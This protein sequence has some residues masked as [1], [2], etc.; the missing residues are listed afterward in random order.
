LALDRL[1][2]E[3]HQG[4]VVHADRLETIFIPVYDLRDHLGHFFGDHAQG[5]LLIVLP[6][7]AHASQPLNR[8]VGVPERDDCALE[9]QRAGGHER[10]RPHR[11]RE[12]SLPRVG[13]GHAAG[14]LSSDGG[15]QVVD[16]ELSVVGAR[17]VGAHHEG[18]QGGPGRVGADQDEGRRVDVAVH[19]ECGV[20]AFQMELPLGGGSADPHVHTGGRVVD[21]RD[22][23]QYQ[24]VGLHHPGAESQGRRV[25]NSRRAGGGIAYEGVVVLDRVGETGIVAE[26]GVVLPRGVKPARRRPKKGVSKA[27][28]VEPPG[29]ASEECVAAGGVGGAGVAP[30][31]GVIP[32]ERVGKA[33][34]VSEKGVVAARGVGETGGTPE[35]GVVRGRVGEAGEVS[36]ERVECASGIAVAGD[37]S[38]ER[39][40][41]TRGVAVAGVAA[42]KGVIVARGV[43]VAG[44][45]AE[46]GVVGARSVGETG[47]PTE[48]GVGVSRRIGLPADRPKKAFE[49]PVVLL[50]PAERP[51]KALSVPPVLE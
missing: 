25:G 31:E 27:P 22:A 45:I 34:V 28:S 21:S 46:E 5:G 16:D 20:V 36:E 14:A 42:E 2:Q 26:E 15:S 44:I 43:G 7:E 6:D 9:A 48:E 11:P 13:D 3:R 32:P 33:G 41:R 50:K 12:V 30:E 8:L 37:V 29:A 4:G 23:P 24:A 39:V 49:K 10:R 17:R 19:P 47:V 35:E 40:L 1:D 38:E 51:K 18:L